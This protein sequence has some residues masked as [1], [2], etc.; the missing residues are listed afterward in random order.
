M[1]NL[2]NIVFIYIYIYIVKWD[3]ILTIHT[4]RCYMDGTNCMVI[5]NTTLGRPSEMTIDFE[6]NR[7]CWG[8]TLLKTIS[9]MDFDGT[10]S[11][12][13]ILY[14]GFPCTHTNQ[15][16]PEDSQDHPCHASDCAQLCFGVPNNVSANDAPKL[17]KQCACRQGYKINLD[18]GHTCQKDSSE[19]SEPLCTSNT[20]QFQVSA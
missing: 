5:R 11:I 7:L 2:S 14:P 3:N 16:I 6:Q 20:T 10:K 18:N 9:C 17:L 13:I 8:D 1:K 4:F 12:I 19:Q 15:P